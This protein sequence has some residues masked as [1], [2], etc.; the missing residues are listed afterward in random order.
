MHSDATRGC[1]RLWVRRQECGQRNPNLNLLFREDVGLSFR[2]SFCLN[3]LC[4]WS[5]DFREEL[6]LDS[7][8]PRHTPR[9]YETHPSGVTSVYEWPG[10]YQGL[11]SSR[12]PASNVGNC[13]TTHSTTS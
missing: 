12:G 11:R 6:R 8:E 5:P 4:G 10:D 3:T 7:R 13:L 2:C 9:P 1:L